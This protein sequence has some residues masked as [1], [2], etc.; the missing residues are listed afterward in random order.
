[1]RGWLR[2]LV[3]WAVSDAIVALAEPGS[4]VFLRGSGQSPHDAAI[5]RFL[6]DAGIRVVWGAE[7]AVVAVA[8][9][10]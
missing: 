5:S 2:R 8:K 9:G 6:T 10:L 4:V 1:M 7:G 3:Q